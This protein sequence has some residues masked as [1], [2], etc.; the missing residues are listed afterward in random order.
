[1]KDLVKAIINIQEQSTTANDF[2]KDYLQNA[3]Q[4]ICPVVKEHFSEMFPE[5]VESALKIVNVDILMSI[6][7]KPEETFKIEDLIS[8]L[9][10]SVKIEKTKVNFTT[11]GTQDKSMAIELLNEIITVFDTQYLPFVEATQ[12]IILPLLSYN[13]NHRVRG[14]SSCTLPL[15][16]K[17]VKN[18]NNNNALVSLAKLYIST[19]VIQSEKEQDNSTLSQ[20]LDNLS[21]C[22]E[23]TGEKFL[24]P[25]E[26][27]DLF[28][29]ILIIFA[30][31]EKRRR[32]LIDKQDKLDKLEEEQ[33][34]EGKEIEEDSDQED[35]NDYANDLEQDIEDIEDILVSLADFIG[36]LFKTH[37]QAALSIV[38]KLTKIVL[39]EY[40]KA[41]S[42]NFELKM[43][44]FIVDDMVEHLGQELLSGIWKD[45]ASILIKYCTNESPE[46]RQAAVYG[47]GIFAKVTKSDFESYVDSFLE[48]ID[49][50]INIKFDDQDEE[51][52][53]HSRDNSI[54]AL[55]KIIIH[56]GKFIKTLDHW[57]KTWIDY[58]P[59]NYDEGES[60]PIHEL[61][62]NG[63]MN[64]A[65]IFL[66]K[67]H[68]NLFQIVK[69]LTTIYKTKHSN[70]KVDELA[71]TI[72]KQIATNTQMIENFKICIVY[73]EE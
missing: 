46:I 61:L 6:S 40:F 15:I 58:L 13:A 71:K 19:T 16:L 22:F 60:I 63:I 30:D 33:E 59:L 5:I 10:P 55:G 51:E 36:V 41:T 65:E 49:S 47:L 20:M 8:S 29:K 35:E 32:L 52:Y 7:N 73:V 17:I 27:N 24:E 11:S 34:K 28:E 25:N 9:E 70:D 54:A 67:N 21:E 68:S 62:C 4:R 14:H 3:W 64:S 72:L 57:I 48:T 26:L 44:I 1:M 66:G 2:T 37:K 53:G 69:V 38:D 45:L 42:S 43:G 18:S 50:S 12:K 23:I 31:T 56:Q 39:P